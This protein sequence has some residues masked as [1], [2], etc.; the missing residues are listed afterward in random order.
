M[1]DSVFPVTGNIPIFDPIWINEW[2]KNRM[3]NPTPYK[4]SKLEPPRDAI[5]SILQKIIPYKINK[6][7]TP[8]NPHSSAYAAKIKSV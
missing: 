1:N 2:T 4:I 3:V 8:T 5:E 6:M 7:I